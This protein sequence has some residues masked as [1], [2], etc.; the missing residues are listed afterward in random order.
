MIGRRTPQFEQTIQVTAAPTQVIAAF[1]DPVALATWWQT[2]RS[3]T[4]PRPLGV[5]A[6]E[7]AETPFQDDVLG[8]L[9]GVF[10]GTVMEF[11]NGREF[12][13]TDAHW[14]PPESDAIGPMVLEVSCEVSGPA[15]DLRVRQSSSDGGE[16]WAR[17]YELVAS[18]WADSLVA[19]K[20]YL[21][22]GA[23]P[24]LPARG[25]GPR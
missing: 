1:F 12:L 3:V 17:Y 15:T 21:E 22:Q 11:R 18:G 8:S 6:V 20:H 16:R 7:W 23:E 4:T 25:L 19:L 2:V 5:Y 13:V 24:R 14:L 10:Y 9:G